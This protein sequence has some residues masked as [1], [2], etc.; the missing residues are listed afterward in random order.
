MNDT[1]TKNNDPITVTRFVRGCFVE[2]FD[3]VTSELKMGVD[4]L[5]GTTL[6][7]NINYR[8]SKLKVYWSVCRSDENFSKEMGKSIAIAKPPL[9]MDYDPE[10]TLVENIIIFLNESTAVVPELQ[11]LERNLRDNYCPQ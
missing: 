4:N 11:A 3:P 9:F 7:I 10:Y 5:G 6:V 8:E 1:V 2:G